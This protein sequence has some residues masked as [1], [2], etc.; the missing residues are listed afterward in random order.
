MSKRQLTLLEA[1]DAAERFAEEFWAVR[2]H[3]LDGL[4]GRALRRKKR[5]LRDEC[6]EHVRGQLVGLGL[7]GSAL[8][9]SVI[10]WLTHRLLNH[11]FGD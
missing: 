9:A 10:G 6:E 1:Q 8:L 11:W 2:R 3:E 5:E 7:I 4:R